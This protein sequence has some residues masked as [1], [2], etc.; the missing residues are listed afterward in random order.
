MSYVGAFCCPIF[1]T[2]LPAMELSLGSSFPEAF[3][4]LPHGKAH[5][6][7]QQV[8]IVNDKGTP[9]EHSIVHSFS[10]WRSQRFAGLLWTTE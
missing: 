10:T 7:S 4:Y 6:R 3:L 1:P 8:I 5:A 9:G 2:W